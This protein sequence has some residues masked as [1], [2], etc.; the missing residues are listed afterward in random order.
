MIYEGTAPPPVEKKKMPPPEKKKKKDAGAAEASAATIVVNL[1]ADAK[2]SVDD[3][4]TQSTSATRVFATPVLDTDK[5][6]AY[7]LKAEII[8]DG[9]TITRTQRVT[10]RA[11]EESRVGF[12]FPASSVAVN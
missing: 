12:E 2:L 10:V 8:R 7:T 3:N 6:Y 1:P 5:E 4:I 9:K 11:G